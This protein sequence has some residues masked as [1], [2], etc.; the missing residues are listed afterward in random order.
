MCTTEVSRTRLHHQT[1]NKKTQALGF[2]HQPQRTEATCFKQALVIVA[3]V[4][5]KRQCWL[6]EPEFNN[7]LIQKLFCNGW[8]EKLRI[9]PKC[10][11]EMHYLKSQAKFEKDIDSELHLQQCLRNNRQHWPTRKLA[12]SPRGTPFRSTSV[13]NRLSKLMGSNIGA[14]LPNFPGVLLEVT[15]RSNTW[16]GPQKKVK[17]PRC[18]PCFPKSFWR[19]FDFPKGE[20]SL[21]DSSRL[22][23]NP[24]FGKPNDL[25]TFSKKNGQ[26]VTF[27]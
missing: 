23:W 15:L 19:S 26:H 9:S 14:M 6:K 12:T 10:A 24:Q 13:V 25:E 27:F 3:L 2:H 16:G 5:R 7:K 22:F 21:R 8:P 4:T 11:S 17:M 20:H 1:I 18:S